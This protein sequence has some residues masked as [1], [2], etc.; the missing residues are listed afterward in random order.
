MDCHWVFIAFYWILMV[1]HCIYGMLMV[2][3]CIFLDFHGFSLYF[4]EHASRVGAREKPHG[5]PGHGVPW[6]LYSPGGLRQRAGSV[7]PMTTGWAPVRSP[8]G[9]Q[10]TGSH[11]SLIARVASVRGL[12][13]D[14]RTTG[15]AP[16]RSPVGPQG[17]GSHVFL[18]CPGGLRKRGGTPLYHINQSAL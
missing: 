5:T 10:G 8:M 11:V 16:A 4:I 18:F 14:P 7:N 17:T 3:R 13:V 2:C 15:W 9:P 6:F 12:G 1:F